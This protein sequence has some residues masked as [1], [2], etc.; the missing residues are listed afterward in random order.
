MRSTVKPSLKVRRK[1]LAV[2]ATC[3]A[4]GLG[5][6]IGVSSAAPSGNPSGIANTA[7]S[8]GHPHSVQAAGAVAPVA[9]LPAPA[10][11][12]LGAIGAKAAAPLVS[13]GTGSHAT[14]VYAATDA[15]GATCIE[16]THAGGNIAEPANCVS[17]AYLRVWSDASGTGAPG[18]G[19]IVS[20]R[21]VA[22]VSTEVRTVRVTFADGSSR[23]LSPDANG[24]VTLETGAGQAVPTSV[25][26]ID[27]AGTTLASLST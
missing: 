10:Q 27:A 7:G 4:V 6:F 8:G 15:G 14:N 5:A 3:A 24:L 13:V 23:D 19:T 12:A 25:S 9:T 2:L 1:P 26:A 16:V 22:A 20:K 18:S 21:I 11:A 17:D